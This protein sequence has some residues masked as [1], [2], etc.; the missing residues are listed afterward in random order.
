MKTEKRLVKEENCQICYDSFET[1]TPVIFDKCG[2]VFCTICLMEIILQN[3]ANCPIDRI[4]CSNVIL[5]LPN[6][7]NTLQSVAEY[8][9]FLVN[10]SRTVLEYMENSFSIFLSFYLR[11]VEIYLAFK[12]KF[13]EFVEKPIDI[14]CCLQSH[15][16]R[17]YKKSFNENHINL[18]ELYREINLNLNKNRFIWDVLKTVNRIKLSPFFG[19][20]MDDM[21]IIVNIGVTFGIEITEENILK[22]CKHRESSMYLLDRIFHD[23]QSD[24]NSLQSI[25]KYLTKLIIC[26]VKDNYELYSVHHPTVRGTD[27]EQ[28]L[29]CRETIKNRNYSKFPECSHKIC[30]ACV[31]NLVIT[32]GKCPIDGKELNEL[33]VCDDGNFGNCHD[34]SSLIFL[35][36]SRHEIISVKTKNIFNYFHQLMWEIS[37]LKR[38]LPVLMDL[39]G[40]ILSEKDKIAKEN[41]I[42]VL[43]NRMKDFEREKYV[44]HFIILRAEIHLYGTMSTLAQIDESDEDDTFF[45]EITNLMN[46]L[47]GYSCDFSNLFFALYRENEEMEITE[48]LLNFKTAHSKVY[49]QCDHVIYIYDSFIERTGSQQFRSVLENIKQFQIDLFEET[50]E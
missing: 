39:I 5:K 11:F 42:Y 33:V 47:L 22:L 32:E 25:K 2:H 18:D 49:F 14:S 41:L 28:C 6:G 10:D 34:K 7:E 27:E 13:K 24:I 36:E 23:L 40:Q 38:F 26:K 8:Q 20:L 19:K 37:D 29:V 17:E 48:L 16:I 12:V 31:K 21:E 35:N 43:T 44:S 50:L 1:L 15:E 9:K 30:L 4:E 46:V 45:E 3:P